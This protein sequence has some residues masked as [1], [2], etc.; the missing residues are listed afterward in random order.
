MAQLTWLGEDDLHGGGAG[1]SFTEAFGGI[2]F[3]KGKPVEVRTYGF[4]QKAL[5][6]PYFEVSDPDDVDDAP[7]KKN[8]GGRPSKAEIEAKM[9]DD[10]R[11]AAAKQAGAQQSAQN[12]GYNPMPNQGASATAAYPAPAYIPPP[13]HEA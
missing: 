11:A 5:N 1:P 8:K 7:E 12:T 9:A 10:R 13:S 4:V 3:P 2:K 6:N